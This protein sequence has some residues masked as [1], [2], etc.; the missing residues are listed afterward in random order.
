M[1][2]LFEK[3][4]YTK[5]YIDDTGNVYSMSSYFNRK[6][7]REVLREKKTTINKKRGY[8]YVRTRTKNYQL[9]R[10]VASVFLDNPEN[11]KTVNHKNGDK[12]DNR[13]ENLEWATF[14][15][16]S[17]HAKEKGLSHHLKKNEGNIKY[18]NKQCQDVLE[19]IKSGMTYLKAG[20]IH[21]MPYST[22]AHLSRGSRRKI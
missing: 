2:V 15:E 22:V 20:S 3:T 8:V 12:T 14:K 17:V 11:K 5:Y 10:L 13:I 6:T 21:N 4:K 19:R 18:S 9:H 16:N 1:K 7:G